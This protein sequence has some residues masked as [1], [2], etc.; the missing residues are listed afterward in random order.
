MAPGGAR[1]GRPRSGRPTPGR[2]RWPVCRRRPPPSTSP[3]TSPRSPPPCATSSRSA[4]TSAPSRMP[5]RPRCATSPHLAVHPPGQHRRGA[6]RPRPG[7]AR[8]AR[9]PHR[10]RAAHRRPGEPADPPGDAA[11][12]EV[13]W[14]R[15]TVDMKGG[16][17]VML[18]VAARGAEPSRDVTFVFYEAEEIDSQYNGLL[19]VEEQRPE[20]IADAD[21]AVLLEPTDARVEGGCKGTLRAEVSTKGIAPTPRGRGRGTTRSTT[22][23]R[24]WPGS[25]RTSRSPGSSTGSSS[26]RRSMPSRLR[27]RRD[28]RHPRPVRRH[29]QLPLRA[30]AL[31]GRRRGPRAPGVL[32]LRRRRGRQRRRRP[33][34]PAPARGQGLRRGA[35]PAGR[36]QAGL[37]RRRALLGD[38]GARPS[39]SAP[40]TR[41]SPTWTTSSARS[42]STSPARP[43]CSAGSPDTGARPPGRCAPAYS[44]AVDPTPNPQA[45]RR[46]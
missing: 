39:T 14:G 6:H 44:G 42:S 23:A 24:C 29:R 13:L 25:S 5:S 28:Q 22:P 41:T 17:A 31:G 7:R 34:R 43:R 40:A 33:A 19:H 35:R 21:F 27:R 12:R 1:H 37:D 45:A 2:L 20:L 26:A 3:P 46:P 38:R 10:H 4:S 18:R 30:L 9:R 16:V 15:G 11:G 36:G 8:G 32:R